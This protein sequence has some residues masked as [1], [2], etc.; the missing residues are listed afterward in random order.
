MWYRKIDLDAAIMKQLI[1][2]Q[3]VAPKFAQPVAFLAGH[4]DLV[5]QLMGGEKLLRKTLPTFC[6]QA[7]TMHFIEGGHWIQQEK[8]VEVNAVLFAWLT[9]HRQLF[10]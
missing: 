6:D 9:Q 4:K 5:V 10:M 2:H 3:M 8:A 1:Q 7:P